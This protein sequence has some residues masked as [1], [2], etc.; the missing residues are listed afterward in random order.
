MISTTQLLDI[1][2]KNEHLTFEILLK[3]VPEINFVDY[4]EALMTHKNI[5]KSSLINTANLHRTY[6]YQIFN[7]TK[8]PS[9]NK[10]IQLALAMQLDIR[11]TNNLLSLSNNGYLYPKVKFD[12]TIL[13]A[14]KNKYSVLE[15]NL[16]LEQ[17]QLPLLDS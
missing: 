5:S 10:V 7:G 12:A 6:A 4:L 14:L 16:I 3:Q 1:I 11:E 15:T 17:Y 2:N 9:R 13:L 8:I